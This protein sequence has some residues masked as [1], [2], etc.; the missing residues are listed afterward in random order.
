MKLIHCECPNKQAS[1]KN[2]WSLS[3]LICNVRYVN[4]SNTDQQQ[5]HRC[6][7]RNI[8]LAVKCHA[9]D[10]VFSSA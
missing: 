1:F 3:L 9:Y 6:H 8:Q 2:G 5:K 10:E 7:M 4:S